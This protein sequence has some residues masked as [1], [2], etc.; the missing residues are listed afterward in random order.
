[1]KQVAG[2]IIPIRYREVLNFLKK[3]SK[4]IGK[5]PSDVG[6][7]SLRRAGSYFMHIL[8]VP[9]EDIKCVGDWKSL[10]ALS[11]LISPLERKQNIDKMVASALAKF[12]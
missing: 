2:K 9:L 3:I 12:G 8:G 7:H 5:N 6:L 11:Y 1:M 4:N 10:A